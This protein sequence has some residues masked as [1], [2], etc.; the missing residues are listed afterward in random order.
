MAAKALPEKSVLLQLLRYD[1]ATGKLFWRERGVEW[2]PAKTPNRSA[3]L[4]MLWNSM[5]A[6]KEA[7]TCV[8]NG[9][10]A[11]AIL[12]ENYKAHR[13]IW[14]MQTGY[15]PNCI[16]H[17]NGVRADNR[18]ENLR[19]VSVGENARNR[20]RPSTNRTGVIG[21]YRW[22]YYGHVYWVATSPSKKSGTYFHCIGAA[23]KFRKSVEMEHNFHQNHGRTF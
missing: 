12:G 14:K 5:N 1:Q 15:E 6:D 13:V 11:G 18:M 3:S 16:D 19:D 2:F 23:L 21:L 4:C 20:R 7:L 17:I 9:Y 22:A 10:R 8:S